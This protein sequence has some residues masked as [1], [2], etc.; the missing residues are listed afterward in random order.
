MND[1]FLRIDTAMYRVRFL[2][3]LNRAIEYAGAKKERVFVLSIPDYSVTPFG[4]G[5]AAQIA[6][7]I[8]WFNAIKQTGDIADGHKLYRYHSIFSDCSNG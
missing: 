1:Q 4:A 8:D 2:Q 6:M 7:E 3:C 5:N